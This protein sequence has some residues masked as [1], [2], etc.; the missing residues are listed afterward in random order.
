MDLNDLGHALQ[1]HRDNVEAECTRLDELGYAFLRTYQE[2]LANEIHG[3]S[4]RLCQEQKRIS[5]LFLDYIYSELQ[6]D[7]EEQAR[8]MK[9][10]LHVLPGSQS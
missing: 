8:V 2:S 6:V 3:I 4:L 7:Q 1:K 10:L 5:D 9:T